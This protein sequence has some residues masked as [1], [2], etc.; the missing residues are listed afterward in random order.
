MGVAAFHSNA[1]AV[2]I[3]TCSTSKSNHVSTSPVQQASSSLIRSV[4][5][6]IPRANP[7]RITR[8]AVALNVRAASRLKAVAYLLQ[9]VSTDARMVATLTTQHALHVIRRC[10]LSVSDQA[11]TNA[12]SVSKTTICTRRSVSLTVQLRTSHTRGS[13][14]V[15]FT[16]A[17]CFTHFLRSLLSPAATSSLQAKCEYCP[18]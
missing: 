9:S 4:S 6:V 1:K 18:E 14:Q 8:R 10:A 16:H 17:L 15:T 3:V 7:A 13:T 12:Q 11:Q 5:P 2:L